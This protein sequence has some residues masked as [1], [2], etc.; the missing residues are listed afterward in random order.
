M[1]VVED[2]STSEASRKRVREALKEKGID[3]NVNGDTVI[4]TGEVKTADEV[5]AMARSPRRWAVVS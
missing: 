5:S 4:L 3:L 2:S 1:R